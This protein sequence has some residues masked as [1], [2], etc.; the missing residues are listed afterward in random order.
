MIEQ[1]RQHIVRDTPDL[2]IILLPDQASHRMLASTP[3]IYNTVNDNSLL[4]PKVYTRKCSYVRT[5][6]VFFYLYVFVTKAVLHI[7]ITGRR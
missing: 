4:S 1:L 7:L 3:I 5:K 2:L 6:V